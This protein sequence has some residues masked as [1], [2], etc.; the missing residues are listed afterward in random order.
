MNFDFSEDQRRL[1]EEI[2]RVLADHSSSANVRRVLDG[3]EAYCANTW[4]QLAA[5]GALGLAI[6]EADGGAD[7]GMLEL[8]LL[9]EESGRALAAVPLASCLYQAGE[10]IRRSGNV[11][12]RAAW[13]P[14]IASGEVIATI[15]APLHAQTILPAAPAVLSDRML[16]G[17]FNAVADGLSATLAVVLAGDALVLLD[18]NAPQVTRLAQQSLDPTRPLARVQCDGAPV[19]VLLATGG[20]ALTRQ[21]INGAAVL[22]AF[23]QVGG[24]EAALY[25]ARDYALERKAFGRPIG[26]FQAVKHKLADMFVA[27]ELARSHAYYGAWALATDAPEL[28]RTAAAARVAASDAYIMVSEESLHLHGGIGYTWEMD[29]HLHLRRAR[30]LAQV[31][32]SVHVWREAL[33]AHLIEEQAA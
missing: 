18:L 17:S 12:Q 16:S 21:V 8:C 7:M 6:N 29:C 11:A 1:Q 27:V 24:A 15:I 3:D 33:A 22:L 30:S 5:L 28:P 14:R 2:R 13:L 32:G 26:G 31:L 4:A 19:E 25:A 10:L 9:A 23:E 20:L